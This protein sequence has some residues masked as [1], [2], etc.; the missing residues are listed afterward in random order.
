[1]TTSNCASLRPVALIGLIILLASCKGSKK[2]AN[3]A[4][5]DSPAPA[6]ARVG[7]LPPT[8]LNRIA[9]SCAAIRL[10][11]GSMRQGVV[12]RSGQDASGKFEYLILA[13]TPSDLKSIVFACGNPGQPT[14]LSATR[15]GDSPNGLSFFSASTKLSLPGYRRDPATTGKSFHAIRLAAGDALPPAESDQIRA[16]LQATLKS[17]NDA[18]RQMA[19]TMMNHR[20]PGPRPTR[21]TQ[22]PALTTK[23]A[24]LQSRLKF[25][26]KSIS[27]TE[28][29]SATTL[30]ELESSGAALEN[31]LLATSEQKVVAI[32]HEGKWVNIEET[33]AA[34]PNEPD[35]VK[36]TVSGSD[37]S[38]SLQCGLVWKL[39]PEAAEFSMVAA[40]TYELESTGSGTLAERLA[41]VT[42]VPFP[43]SGSTRSLSANL[44]WGGL[45]TTLWMR[46]FANDHPEKPL[47]DESILLEYNDSLS[48]KWA[49]PPSPLIAIPESKPDVPED[50]VKDRAVIQTEGNVL[51]L[52]AAD[53]GS[54][55]MVRT[56]KPPYWSTLDLKTGATA[57]LPWKTTADTLLATQADKVYLIDRKSK[58]GEVWNTSTTKREAVRLLPVDGDIVAV[59]APR[60][61]AE[62][63]ILVT[64]S[65]GAYFVRP[66]DFKIVDCGIDLAPIFAQVATRSYNLS[67]LDPASLQLRAS[68]DGSIYTISGLKLDQDSERFLTLAL[69]LDG[70][71]VIQSNTS[72]PRIIPTRGRLLVPR[73]PDHGGRDI[74]PVGVRQSASF[75][76]P[77]GAIEFRAADERRALA[78]LNSAPIVPPVLR[79]AGRSRLAFDRGLYLDSTFGVLLI[80]DADRIH[81]L[82]LQLPETDMLPPAFVVN[83]E[84]VTFPLPAGTG[85]RATSSAGGEI[86]ISA[87]S[88]KWA[89]PAKANR[90]SSTLRLDWT[91]ELGSPMNRSITFSHVSPASTPEATSPDGSRSIPLNRRAMLHTTESPIGVAGAGHVLLTSNSDKKSAWSLTTGERLCT[92]EVSTQKFFGDADHLYSLGQTGR[93][94][95]YDIHTG[96]ELKTQD[97]GSQNQ[98]DRRG[99]KLVATGFA[100]RGPLLA[101]I[102]EGGQDYLAQID[103]DTL[104]LGLVDF[105]TSKTPFSFPRLTPNASGS[106]CW[107]IAAAIL[108]EGN[109]VTLKQP[110]VSVDGTPGAS[111]RFVVSENEVV[112]TG[113]TPPK[114]IPAENLPGGT[115]STK[116]M[117]DQSGHYLL[118]GNYDQESESTV[119]SVRQ[120]DESFRELFKLQFEGRFNN[121]QHWLISGTKTL[122]SPLQGNL[123]ALGVFELDIPAIQAQLAKAPATK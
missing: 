52:I 73:Y 70:D 58:M 79:S 95:S 22:D 113:S 118:M 84:T 83:G 110:N 43:K 92:V 10:P 39:A 55:L 117:I 16:E 67:R 40:T 29:A 2:D 77:Q 94:K 28:A 104:A 86:A 56:D 62:K 18:R 50:F 15:K 21:P 82:H 97:F 30:E 26:L 107:A 89:V 90:S 49:K 36:L 23:L 123:G 76:A 11:D 122:V 120:L 33:L 106:V 102:S 65:T 12:I 51:D 25:P 112:D 34:L 68:A 121:G 103:R 69:T 46:I 42:P 6:A 7:A 60:S 105:G 17:Q 114:S 96:N 109:R 88:L 63:P 66:A 44:T 13:D 64:T 53:D 24:E 116:L 31:T 81:L 32:R 85:H 9:E 91:G 4:P 75:P 78:S 3:T 80:P 93:L 74:G 14:I 100:S 71:L 99:L 35:Q 87:E 41:R 47:I 54:V 98:G 5:A 111:G 37:S 20:G 1:M 45:P 59:T 27:V 8:S 101:V 72:D 61:A 19:E 48:A 115:P 57:N 108:R 119:C 38:V